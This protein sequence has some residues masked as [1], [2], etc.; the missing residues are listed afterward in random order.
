VFKAGKRCADKE[1][2]CNMPS[3]SD[4]SEIDGERCATPGEA[5]A[6]HLKFCE[7]YAKPGACRD[8]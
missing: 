3:L 1:C 6:L 2:G 7:K 8:E 4:A 5:Q